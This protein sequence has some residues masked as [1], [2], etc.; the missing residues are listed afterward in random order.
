MKTPI[1][2]TKLCRLLR[3]RIHDTGFDYTI[4]YTKSTVE[5]HLLPLSRDIEEDYLRNKRK[6]YIIGVSGPP[7]SG[8]SSISS[9]LLQMLTNRGLSVNILPLDGFHLRNQDLKAK[10]IT[11]QNRSYSL[12]ELKGA[13]ETYDVK[14]LVE[15]LEKL[16]RGGGFF[17]PLYLRTIHE[18]VDNG[19]FISNQHGI[20]IIEGNYL[21]LNVSPWKQLAPFFQKKIFILPKK[22]FLK[23]RIVRRK[24]RGGYSRQEALMHF[25]RSDLRNINEVLSLSSGYDLLI[26]QRGRYS[27]E[28]IRYDPLP[29]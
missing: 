3:Y 8:K 18:P 26:R 19:L 28:V 7:G 17:W 29:L 13:K 16:H 24:Q 5:K 15:C 11:V 12:H 4:N 21:F 27:Y 1:K 10:R 6:L 25:R 23:G 14:K 20:Y 22:K 9:I 2:S